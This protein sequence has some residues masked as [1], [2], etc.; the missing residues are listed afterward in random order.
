MN[1]VASASFESSPFLQSVQGKLGELS[2]HEGVRL[3][4]SVARQPVWEKTSDGDEV[5]VR[6]ACW[7]VE[8]HGEELTEPEFE[9]LSDKVTQ[10]QLSRELP[11]FFPDI[12]I[13]VDDDIEI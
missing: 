2:G 1:N 10:E 5:L 3:R 12:E 13:V 11:V 9:V 6:W 7:T 8:K 4:V